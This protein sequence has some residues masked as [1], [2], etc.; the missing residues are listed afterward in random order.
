MHGLN[1]FLHGNIDRAGAKGSPCFTPLSKAMGFE[2]LLFMRNLVVELA[3][4]DFIIW[5]R[6]VGKLKC[7][8]ALIM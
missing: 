4:R 6:G 2:S 8:S 7:S 3:R 5:V 1:S